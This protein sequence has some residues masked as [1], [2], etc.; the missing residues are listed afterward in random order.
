MSPMERMEKKGRVSEVFRAL[1]MLE[2]FTLP[3]EDTLQEIL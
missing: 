3:Q 1:A 2:L